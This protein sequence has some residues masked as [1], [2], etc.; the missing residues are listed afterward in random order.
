MK[1][2]RIT[3][4]ACAVAVTLLL[5]SCTEQPGVLYRA[6]DPGAVPPALLHLDSD[7]DL[8]FVQHMVASLNPNGML[9]VVLPHGILFRGGTVSFHPILRYSRHR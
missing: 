2:L 3:P 1:R 7:G 4:L 5:A 8:A 6:P 9:G